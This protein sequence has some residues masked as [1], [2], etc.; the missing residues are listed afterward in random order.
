[1]EM[2]IIPEVEEALE[3]WDKKKK[4]KDKKEE[5]DEEEKA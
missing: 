3:S 2:T 4:Q 1:M 5:D